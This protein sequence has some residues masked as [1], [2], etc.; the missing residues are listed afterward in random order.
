MTQPEHSK[1]I[2]KTAG[3][4]LKPYGIVR[5]GQSRSWLDDHGWF[6]SVI[7]F[8]PSSWNRGTYLNVGVN[9]H[10][11]R[12]DYF[13]YDIGGRESLFEK[14]DNTEQF[15]INIEGFANKALGI[16]LNYREAFRNLESSGNAILTHQFASDSLWGN[17][18]RGVVCGITNKFG[19]ADKYFDMLLSVELDYD[20]VNE[21]KRDTLFLKTVMNSH[22][23]FKTEII[24]IIKATRSLKKLPPVEIELPQ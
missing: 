2:V 14:F 1:I 7:E 18:H 6:T 15:T 3:Q 17:Y 16:A 23:Q 13:S 9:F 11:F 22:Q 21:L 8:Q 20:W 24:E 5:K 19:E 10:W 4:I 12:K